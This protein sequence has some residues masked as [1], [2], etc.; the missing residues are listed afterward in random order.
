MAATC[1]EA[2]YTKYY[3]DEETSFV[4][5]TGASAT[6]VH[7]D[8]DNDGKCDVCGASMYTYSVT[9]SWEQTGTA[10]YTEGTTTY[11]W[12]AQ[13]VK[14]VEN[15]KTDGNWSSAS[16]VTVKI[17]NTGTGTVK[18]S[19]SYANA[20]GFTADT[21]GFDQITTVSGGNDDS[22]TLTVKP[23]GGTIDKDNTTIGEITIT[24]TTGG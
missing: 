16:V 22:A 18:A 9:I 7:K 10:K 17:E 4:K 13:N 1:V 6:G 14:W 21:S 19:Y 11:R 20:D 8:T 12:D 2:G 15:G 23:T 3:C 24:L 5:V